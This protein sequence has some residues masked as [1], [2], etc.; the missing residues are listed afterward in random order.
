ME[1]K[2]LY[3]YY[4]DCGRM[5]DLTSIFIST[6]KEIKSIIGKKVNFGEAL[7][8]HSEVC[9]ELEEHEFMI[10]SKDQD[11]VNK[12][13]EILGTTISGRNPFYYLEEE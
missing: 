13:L 9:G 8:K 5:G 7:G 4:L 3:K 2:Y 10:L 6:P 12:T 11:Y 1:E